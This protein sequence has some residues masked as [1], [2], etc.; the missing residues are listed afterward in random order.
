MLSFSK[1][2]RVADGALD[3]AAGK[4]VSEADIAPY[5]NLDTM[6]MLWFHTDQFTFGDMVARRE[7]MDAKFGYKYKVLSDL[8]DFETSEDLAVKELRE[9][10]Q[11]LREEEDALVQEAL[12]RTAMREQQ[13]MRRSPASTAR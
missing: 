12:N 2:L 11:Q 5:N 13:P 4:A 1:L 10:L 9:V 6:P 7:D 3:G 8:D